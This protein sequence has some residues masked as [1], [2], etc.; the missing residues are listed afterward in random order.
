MDVVRTEAG[1]ISGTVIGEPDHPVR[2]YRGIPYAAPPLGDLRWK[3]PQPVAP[4]PGIRECTRFSAQS[5]QSP[6][7][8][9]P[10]PAADL[11]ESEDCLYLNVLAPAMDPSDRLPV[12]VWLHGGGFGMWTGNDRVYNGSRLPSNGV[13]VVTVNMRL[14]PLGLLAHPLL[15]RES[16]H[17]VSGNYLF[18]DM[19]AA[20]QWVQ[21]NIDAFG[22]DAGNVTIF[23]ESGGAM[24]VIHLMDSPLAKGLFHRA[25]AQSGVAQGTPLFEMEAMGELLFAGLGIDDTEDPLAAARA[26]PWQKIIEAGARL[27]TEMAGPLWTAAVDGWF[28]PDTT[29][30]IFKAGRQNAVPFIVGADRGELNSPGVILM[31][32][33]VPAYLDLFAGARDAG[34]RAYAYVFDHVPAGW[35][36]DGAVCAH[37]MEIPYVFGDWDNHSGFWPVV[38]YLTQPS[39]AKSPDP[40]LT[41]MDRR[42]SELT[43]SLWANFARTGIPGVDGEV[44]WPAWDE[45]SDQ[46]LNIAESPEVRSGFSTI[47]QK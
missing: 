40:G 6:V 37:T 5:C 39:G 34:G 17:G 9:L 36:K 18:L 33:I 32:W 35:K 1:Y 14:G 27:A 4:W 23:G 15:S 47:A 7:M 13:V 31:P 8:G 43:M 22:G 42:V 21:R 3:P 2:V 30:N 11:P 38:Y 25:I 29:A 24:K 45:A 46:Y 12:M 19:V 20:L 28:L 26:L 16:P 10:N 41:D 44:D